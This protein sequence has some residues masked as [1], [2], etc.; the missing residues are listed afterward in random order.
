[1]PDKKRTTDLDWEDLRYFVALARH[2]SLS[3]TARA[4]RVNHATVS[5]RVTNLEARL[6][7]PLFD[8]HA[9]GYLLTLDGKA[10]LEE[11]TAMDEAALSVLRRIDVGLE[12]CGVV[13]L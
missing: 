9:Q 13:R 11:A 12:L 6:G 10:V 8:R 7:R 2:G 4:L 5:R 1:M 3:A